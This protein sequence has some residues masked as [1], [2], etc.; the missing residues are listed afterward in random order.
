MF[1]LEDGTGIIDSNAYV[2]IPF[3]ENYFMGDR[4]ARFNELSDDDKSAAI[5]LGTQL[6]D[7]SYEWI[8]DRKSLEQGLNW[9]R[10]DA[11]LYGFTLDGIPTAVK[12]AACEAVW[13]S[14][15]ESSLFSNENNKE[16]ASERV[17]VV[18]VSYF[19]PKDISKD[20]VTRFEILDKILRGL[21][22]TEEKS[23]GSSVGSAQVE[24]A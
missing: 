17:D 24:R 4:L 20:T 23:S 1:I 5:I 16:V 14:M 3:V 2:D 11:E 8:G 9:P 7:I 15:T 12:K 18:S 22:R 13:L 19:N 21:F 6:V 10:I